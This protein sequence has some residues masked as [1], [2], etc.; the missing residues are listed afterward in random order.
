MAQDHLIIITEILKQILTGSRRRRHRRSR[1]S[2]LPSTGHFCRF[3]RLPLNTLIYLG[4]IPKKTI[5]FISSLKA[6]VLDHG[7]S[8]LNR[9]IKRFKT[10]TIILKQLKNYCNVNESAFKRRYQNCTL[11][12]KKTTRDTS[13]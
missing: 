11:V 10:T 4:N 9:F 5:F 1:H 6:L 7:I 8:A 3:V 12:L 2:I 13:R